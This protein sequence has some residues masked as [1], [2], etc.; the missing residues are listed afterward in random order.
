MLSSFWHKNSAF[1]IFSFS[2]LLT[3]AA[4]IAVFLIAGP[5]ALLIAMALIVIEITFSFDNAVI[6]ARVLQHLSP[7]WQKIFLTIGIA[8]AVFGMRIVF[9]VA[10]VAVTTALSWREVIDLSLNNPERYEQAL[11]VAEPSIAAF[12]GAFLLMLS[13]HFFMNPKKHVHWWKILERPLAKVPSR[14]IYATVAS[15][16]LMIIAAMPANP[17]P[18]ETIKAGIVGVVTY[19]VIHGL[20]EHFLPNMHHKRVAQTGVAGFVGFFYLE[21]LDASFSL[22]SVIGAFA[23]TNQV[24]LIAAGLGVGAIWVRSMTVYITRRET[25]RV[26]RYLEH[27]AHYAIAILAAGMLT[28]LLIDIPEAALGVVGVAIITASVVASR[29]ANKESLQE[30]AAEIES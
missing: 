18:I 3:I 12:G 23:L 8:I 6:N 9:P 24:L 29:K 5:A 19:L 30:V 7:F 22:D 4:L 27:G 26:Y 21:V 15:T 13:L 1:R 10:I 28:S 25:L 11:A 16:I 17:H 2:G 20:A 14:W